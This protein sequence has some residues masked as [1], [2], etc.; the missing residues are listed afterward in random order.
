MESWHKILRRLFLSIF[1]M[2]SVCGPLM[3]FLLMEFI[4]RQNKR[5]NPKMAMTSGPNGTI[6]THK[7]GVMGENK[8][9]YAVGCI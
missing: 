7:Y 5:L 2:Y 1:S 8:N 6:I 3:P 9:S 4:T